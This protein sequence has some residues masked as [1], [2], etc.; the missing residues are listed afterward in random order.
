MATKYKSD[1]QQ[2]IN[3]P[4]S[5]WAEQAALIDREQSWDKVLRRILRNIVDGEDYVMPATIDD[6]A[7]L[8]EITKQIALA[9]LSTK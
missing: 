1:Y 4:E 6:P 5:F 9:G 8:E 7:I 3:D 2:S